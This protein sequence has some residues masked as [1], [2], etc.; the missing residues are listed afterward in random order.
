MEHVLALRSMEEHMLHLGGARRCGSTAISPTAPVP[1]SRAL[2]L[3]L[4]VLTPSSRALRLASI[5]DNPSAAPK[6]PPRAIYLRFLAHFFFCLSF[7]TRSCA[8]SL[9]SIAALFMAN[10]QTRTSWLRARSVG[11]GGVCV[12]RLR[13]FLSNSVWCCSSRVLCGV[14][15]AHG[16]SHGGRGGVGVRNWV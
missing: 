3:G 7:S 13:Y 9:A 14:S 12:R 10:P 5:R 15:A 2:S 1:S 4:A 16:P 11:L 8:L 6:T